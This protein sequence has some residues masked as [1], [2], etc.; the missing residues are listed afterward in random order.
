MLSVRHDIRNLLHRL[1][2]HFSQYNIDEIAKIVAATADARDVRFLDEHASEL[3]AHTTL[4]DLLDQPYEIT[5]RFTQSPGN[6]RHRHYHDSG[7]QQAGSRFHATDPTVPADATDE[8]RIEFFIREFDRLQNRN[9]FMWAGYVVR[10]LL[11]RL[12]FPPEETKSVLNQLREDEIVIVQ[13]VENPRNPDYPATGV[14][15][16][17]ENETVLEVL[18]DDA[19]EESTESEA[20]AEYANDHD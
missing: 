20:D 6:G 3:P 2:R 7:A 17:Y 13:K 1:A 5:L 10:E 8:E 14:R 15:L 11:P 12:G 4:A 9:E 16:N 18:G 19:Q